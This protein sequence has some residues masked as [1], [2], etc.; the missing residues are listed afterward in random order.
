MFPCVLWV[1][2]H[3]CKCVCA[4]AFSISLRT[5]WMRQETRLRQR[6]PLQREEG[7]GPVGEC[8]MFHLSE[9][10]SLWPERT[11]PLTSTWKGFLRGTE[12]GKDFF[13]PD[14]LI[15]RT[16]RQ[17]V[18]AAREADSLVTALLTGAMT[19]CPLCEPCC[20]H[21]LFM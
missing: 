13:H 4:T 1:C 10:V 6:R 11:F 7:A 12:A 15:Q 9:Q 18:P 8:L 14:R 20:Q 5:T 17:P 19:A 2:A 3:V 16:R 21:T